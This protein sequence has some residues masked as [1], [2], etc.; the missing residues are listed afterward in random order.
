MKRNLI[1]ALAFVS[2]FLLA[3]GSSNDRNEQAHTDSTSNDTV[4]AQAPGDSV[5]LADSAVNRADHVTVDT[6]KKQ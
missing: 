2:T 1:A 6:A 3:C 5:R 4:G